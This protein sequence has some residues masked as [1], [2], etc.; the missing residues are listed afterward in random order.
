MEA[1]K[2]NTITRIITT[3]RKRVFF[4]QKRDFPLKTLLEV[5]QVYIYICDVANQEDHLQ[6]FV[7]F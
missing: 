4:V 3:F 2:V 7:L 6:E 5:Q 1:L